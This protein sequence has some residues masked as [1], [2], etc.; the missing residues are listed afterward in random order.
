MKVKNRISDKTHPGREQTPIENV[1]GFSLRIWKQLSLWLSKHQMGQSN[2][3]STPY[4]SS[5]PSIILQGAWS[6]V[7]INSTKH[8]QTGWEKYHESSSVR[9][10]VQSWSSVPRPEWNPH[11]SSR[12]WVNNLSTFGWSALARISF[13]REV[14]QCDTPIIGA[15]SQCNPG[16]F[17]W[18]YLFFK[19]L[20]TLKKNPIFGSLSL[21]CCVLCETK[22]EKPWKQAEILISWYRIFRHVQTQYSWEDAKFFGSHQRLIELQNNTPQH[23]LLQL[24]HGVSGLILSNR[25]WFRGQWPAEDLTS[26]A[27]STVAK[28][29]RNYMH[30]WFIVSFQSH[31]PADCIVT[32]CYT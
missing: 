13:P 28:L 32:T 22:K 27:W 19:P 5:T 9:A 15:N 2:G 3:A 1:L 10:R 20:N 6:Q 30:G 26:D 11:W 7:F 8:V 29:E 23:L 31:C 4:F 14:E 12:I 21:C 17:R 18:C 16:Q 25:S 24:D